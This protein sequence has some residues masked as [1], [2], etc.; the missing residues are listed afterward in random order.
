MI[1]LFILLVRRLKKKFR[2]PIL[3]TLRAKKVSQKETND[4][5]KYSNRRAIEKYWK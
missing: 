5:S 1:T 3:A 2:K 4:V